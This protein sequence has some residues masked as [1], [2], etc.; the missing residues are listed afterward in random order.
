MPSLSFLE[1]LRNLPL[2][3]RYVILW[4]G[5]LVVFVMIGWIWLYQVQVQLAS[6]SPFDLNGTLFA[7]DTTRE[8]PAQGGGI[9]SQLSNMGGALRHAGASLISFVGDQIP[10]A[11]PSQS[12][13]STAPQE[14]DELNQFLEYQ[15]FPEN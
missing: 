9:L 14:G 4:S 13:P 11:T 6:A 10:S 5:S 8:E 1:K 15:P 2:S 3:Q 7:V 12:S